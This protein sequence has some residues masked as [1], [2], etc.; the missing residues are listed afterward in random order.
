VKARA[1]TGT[2][3]FSNDLITLNQKVLLNKKILSLKLLFHKEKRSKKDLC[4]LRKKPIKLTTVSKIFR[5]LM[6][7]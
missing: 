2:K 3:I 4:F 6:L 7:A 5:V 1:F